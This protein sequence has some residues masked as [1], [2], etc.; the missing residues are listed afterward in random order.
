[1]SFEYHN[2]RTN[3]AASLSDEQFAQAVQQGLIE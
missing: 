1:M 2:L 3:I